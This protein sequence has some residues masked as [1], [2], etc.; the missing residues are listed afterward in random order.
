MPAEETT[1]G[2]ELALER[3]LAVT[4][5]GIE[6]Q[7]QLSQAL[8]T[9]IVIEQAKGVLSERLGLDVDTAFELLR[10]AARHDRIKVHDLA[11][12]VVGS[13]ATPPSIASMLDQQRRQRG[14]AADKV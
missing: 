12:E 2:L 14:R 1:T 13:R 5:A 7:A 10:R 11:A 3:L 8:R 9:R 6:R 4:G